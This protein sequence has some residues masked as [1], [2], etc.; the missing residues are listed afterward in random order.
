MEKSDVA[1]VF[2]VSFD[3]QTGDSMQESFIVYGGY[4]D[5]NVKPCGN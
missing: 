1:P 2:C 5:A 3:L 4:N